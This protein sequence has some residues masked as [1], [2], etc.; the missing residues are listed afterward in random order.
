MNI[1]A[2][3]KLHHLQVHQD[4]VHMHTKKD[5][6]PEIGRDITE[7]MNILQEVGTR[8]IVTTENVTEI[9]ETEK[10]RESTGIDIVI[11]QIVTENIVEVH[12]TT[13]T[14]KEMKCIIEI[15]MS[16][17]GVTAT[18]G[19]GNIVITRDIEQNQETD[20]CKAEGLAYV[21]TV[22][23][24]HIIPGWNRHLSI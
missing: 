1:L 15:D 12:H 9:E 21:V 23:K 16:M 20:T 19:V 11:A 14:E 5:V 13:V 10:G 18:A 7:H 3:I 4:L 6:H 24:G 22:E 17:K 8:L 2:E